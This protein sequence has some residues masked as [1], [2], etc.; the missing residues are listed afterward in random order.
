MQRTVALALM[1][2]T[3]FGSGSM[4]ASAGQR[5]EVTISSG[6]VK[7][8]AAGATETEAYVSVDNPRAY[9]ATLQ[10]P[11]SDAGTV[12]FRR[13]GQNEAVQFVIVPA[14]ESLDMSAKG[15]Y[16]LLRNLKRPL[17]EGDKVQLSMTMETNATLTVE[18][19]VKKN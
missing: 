19:T 5:K 16:L 18:A 9:D 8:P 2:L 17:A 13:A 4:G 1:A 3:V 10:A 12:E 6:W 15:T 7:L 11:T 14:Y